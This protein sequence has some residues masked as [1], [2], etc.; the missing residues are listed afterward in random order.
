MIEIWQAPW[1]EPTFEY[2]DYTIGGTMITVKVIVSED[3]MV[4]QFSDPQAR[5]VM[6]QKLCEEL[7]SEMLNRNLIEINQAKNPYDFSTTILARA[8]CAPN[9]QVKILRT[10]DVK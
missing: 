6:R 3:V 7:A 5:Q 1:Q 10:L 2:R 8:Y 9:D 4:N